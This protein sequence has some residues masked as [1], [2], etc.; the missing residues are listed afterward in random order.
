MVEQD[1]WLTTVYFSL[2]LV[3]IYFLMNIFSLLY[4]LKL[5]SS[6]FECGFYSNITLTMRYKFNYWMII[7]HFMI[8]EQ[9]LLFCFLLLF[10]LHSNA[11]YVFIFLVLFILFV[12]LTFSLALF[13]LYAFCRIYSFTFFDVSRFHRGQLFSYLLGILYYYEL[14]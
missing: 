3:I 6:N 11:V 7:I 12:D 5:N 9:E 13:I 8:F 14:L 2:Y 10:G 1:M 4:N